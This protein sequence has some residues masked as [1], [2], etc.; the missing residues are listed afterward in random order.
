MLLSSIFTPEILAL[1][2]SHYIAW[3]TRKP[4]S[5]FELIEA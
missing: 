5:R 1:V 4:L 2:N 3:Q